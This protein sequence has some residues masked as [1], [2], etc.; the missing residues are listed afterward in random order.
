MS[1]ILS[2]AG[3]N[4]YWMDSA[5]KVLQ[6]LKRWYSSTCTREMALRSQIGSKE[7]PLW[8]VSHTK[9]FLRTHMNM[10]GGLAFYFFKKYLGT[11]FVLTLKILKFFLREQV[12][13][14]L[15][16]FF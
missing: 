1:E 15:M 9:R 11:V 10:L 3:C 7:G 12:A 16:L 4:C 5:R 6:A 2:L 14:F 8:A 13:N